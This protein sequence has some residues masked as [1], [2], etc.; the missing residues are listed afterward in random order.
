MARP[1]CYW[2]R[3][4]STE[5]I[6]HEPKERVKLPVLVTGILIFIGCLLVI[7]QPPASPPKIGNRERP[8]WFADY[9]MEVEV[10]AFLFCPPSTVVVRNGEAVYSSS[11]CSHNITL[12]DM[13]EMYYAFRSLWPWSEC[14]IT[15]DPEF[16]YPRSLYSDPGTDLDDQASYR[17]IQVE[18]NEPNA[19]WGPLDPTATP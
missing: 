8:R 10:F 5:Q 13:Y 16:G 4:M 2:S 7:L 12:D 11:E 1:V 19:T 15:Y 6:H 14:K 9:T 17:V 18:Q 3:T